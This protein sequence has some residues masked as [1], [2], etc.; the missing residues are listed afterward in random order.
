MKILDNRQ[1]FVTIFILF[2]VGDVMTAIPDAICFQM[3]FLPV[4]RNLDLLQLS[5]NLP[6]PILLDRS[7][8]NVQP[9]QPYL[10]SIMG[11]VV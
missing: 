3:E 6:P 8:G 5:L 7:S 10:L 2:S 9:T 11:V 4:S 1:M